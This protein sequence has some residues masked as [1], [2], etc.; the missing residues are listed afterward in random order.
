MKATIRRLNVGEADLYRRVRLESLRESP[1]AFASLYADAFLRTE[2]S[3][4][5]QAD[6][7]AEGGDRATFV[8]LADEPIGVAALY[9]DDTRPE[10]G[11]LMQVWIAPGHR[12]GDLAIGLMDTV[13][14]WASLNGFQTIRA[15]VTHSNG[16]ALRFYEK[17][18]FERG[19]EGNTAIDRNP[20]LIKRVE[21]PRIAPKITP[22]PAS[23]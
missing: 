11:E 19:N 18:G 1:E 7:S 10:D 13:F 3:W 20:I 2:E 9:R 6:A 5:L 12:G 22:A 23:S 15:E 16:R 17:Y 8:I 14:H 4:S 21:R